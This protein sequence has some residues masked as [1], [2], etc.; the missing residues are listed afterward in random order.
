M[1]LQSICVDFKRLTHPK[2][3]RCLNVSIFNILSSQNVI[4]LRTYV[5]VLYFTVAIHIHLNLSTTWLASPAIFLCRSTPLLW[6][7]PSGDV[8]L[9]S[10]FH[11]NGF[12]TPE[13]S[14]SISETG[15]CSTELSLLCFITP[16]ITWPAIVC[17]LS[18]RAQLASESTVHRVNQ[19]SRA[20]FALWGFSHSYSQCRVLMHWLDSF[21]YIM[22]KHCII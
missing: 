20:P 9:V 18:L 4:N 22:K 21:V 5:Y 15:L 19:T 7:P 10:N 3:E 8:G 14:E 13:W 11:T 6:V 12:Q 16:I 1:Y 2:Y 17:Q